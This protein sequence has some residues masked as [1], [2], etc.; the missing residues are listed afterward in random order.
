MRVHTRLGASILLTLLS[1][2]TIV[3]LLPQSRVTAGLHIALGSS[4][5]EYAGDLWTWVRGGKGVADGV[6]VVVFG[7]SWADGVGEDEGRDGNGRGR[8]WAGWLCED[9]SFLI[10]LRM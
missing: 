1:L 10:L 6:A 8:S 4:I 5:D 7:D 2:L 3:L 9:V